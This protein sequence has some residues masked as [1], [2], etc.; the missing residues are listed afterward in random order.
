MH[1]REL[2]AV[3]ARSRALVV[4]RL[5]NS[6]RLDRVAECIAAAGIE[7]MEATLTTPGALEWIEGA[8][9]RHGLTV[10]MGTVIGHEEAERAIES[11]AAFLVSP[12]LDEEVIADAQASDVAALGGAWTPTEVLRA[13][14]AGACAVK[15]FPAHIGGPQYLTDLRGPYP[16]IPLVP[17][18]GIDEGSAASYLRA[19]ALAVGVGG[20]YINDATVEAEEWPA[21]TRHLTALVSATRSV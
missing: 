8:Q 13:W 3:L 2:H 1:P 20:A 10:G 14:R 11:G 6:A 7:V 5:A 4:V 21:L 15:L 12:G 19:G 17:I 9:D 18:G 16:D